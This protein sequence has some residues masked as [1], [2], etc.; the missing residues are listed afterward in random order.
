MGKYDFTDINT[1][2]VVQQKDF[3]LLRNVGRISEPTGLWREQSYIKLVLTASFRNLIWCIN[4][5]KPNLTESYGKFKE[6]HSK[7]CDLT[8]TL[9]SLLIEGEVE[10]LIMQSFGI[11]PQYVLLTW[12]LKEL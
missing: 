10:A 12:R 2:E 11:T 8:Q 5:T 9:S 1:W 6:P 7:K 4:L 3:I